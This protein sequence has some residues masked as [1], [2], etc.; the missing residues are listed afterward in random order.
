MRRRKR[1]TLD[2]AAISNLLDRCQTEDQK[3]FT[4]TLKEMERSVGGSYCIVGKEGPALFHECARIFEKTKKNET[5]YNILRLAK[6]AAESPATIE[7]N[8]EEP[9]EFYL[10]TMFDPDGRIRMGGL[11][12]LDRYYFGLKIVLF[13][14]RPKYNNKDKEKRLAQIEKIGHFVVEKY[15]YLQN[16]EEEFMA[17]HKH[18]KGLTYHDLPDFAGRIPWAADTKN[19]M[20][21]SIRMGIETFSLKGPLEEIMK[22]YGYQEKTSP[23]FPD[24]NIFQRYEKTAEH[25]Q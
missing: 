19:K 6:Y 9:W 17:K 1:P 23:E 25:K 22:Q 7:N 14:Y 2:Q 4:K 11:Q 10:K 5:R 15:I 16:L 21:K 24:L 13:P 12:L 8:H 18:K 20:L 3:T